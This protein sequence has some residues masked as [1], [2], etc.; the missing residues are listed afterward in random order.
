MK[1]LLLSLFLYSFHFSLRAQTVLETPQ[2]NSILYTGPG[3]DQ[4]LIVGLGGSEGRN[5]WASD[6]WKTTRD[7]FLE[8]GYAFL[9]IGYFGA[10]GTPDTLNRISLNAIHDAILKAAGNQKI[11]KKKI[12][13]IGG[14]RGGDLA[15]L[16]GSYFSDIT[17]V[18]AIVPSHVTFPGHT[19]HFST[20]AWTY[21]G[22]ELPYVPV[23]EAAVPALMKRDLRGAFEAMLKDSA[24]EQLAMIPVERI[25]GPV[26]LLSATE[27]E[28]CPSTL[29]CE[30][31]EDRF[32]QHQFPYRTEH[33][34]V[35]GG[36]AAPLTRF[37]TVFAF[38]DKYFKA[39][40]SRPR[41]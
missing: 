3:D 36:H 24:A 30:K 5:A 31:M 1:F 19:G 14:S 16:L 7:R 6:H 32:R 9:A 28:I 39:S 23:N 20:A 29:M 21:N 38:L 2:A 17:C 18:V 40:P 22:K 15:L 25:K 34:A 11:N 8:S 12:A 13:I 35:Q 26:L 33:I 27:D 10:P 37:D 41:R 4:P